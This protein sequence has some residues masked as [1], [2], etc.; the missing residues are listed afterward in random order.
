M[1]YRKTVLPWLICAIAAIFYCYAYF[2]RISPSV[3]MGQLMQGLHINATE[4]GTLA[5]FYY[6]AYTPMQLPVGILI[7]RFG[8]RFVLFSAC[9]IAVLGLFF[10]I[11]ADSFASAAFGRFLIGFGASFSYITVLKLGTLWLP[12]NRF[13]IVAGLTTSFGMIAAAISDKYLAAFVQAIGY[14]DALLSALFAGIL[15]SFV[16]FTVVRNRPNDGRIH[17]EDN[18]SFS[19]LF[20][21]MLT[22][23]KMPQMWL[24]GLIGL[25]LYLPASVFLDVWGIAYLEHV[26]HMTTSQATTAVSMVFLG[27]IISSPLIGAYSDFIGQ[28][29]LPLLLAAAGAFISVSLIFYLPNL[30]FNNV[31]LLFFIFGV[32][33]GSHPLCFSLSKENNPKHLT[34]TATAV[35]NTVIMLGGVIF[36]PV[37]GWLL[38][39]HAKGAVNASGVPVYTAND[40]HFALTII[41]FAMLLSFVLCFF[42]RETHCK[43]AEP[44]ILIDDLETAGIG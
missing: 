7:D 3:M 2:L 28:R 27:W 34:G 14:R 5:A 23:L 38:D 35:T 25:L 6:Y 15:L 21:S 4:F 43:T 16:I 24:I 33:C 8:A 9:L 17:H 37:V 40:Y 18:L 41:P 22:I 20:K 1:N 44:T 36:Q 30:S 12:P 13:A 26:Y 31:Y 10:F 32:F 29:R 39:Y 11:H 19:E 42:L